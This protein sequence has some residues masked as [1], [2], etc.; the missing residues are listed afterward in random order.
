MVYAIFIH[1]F[2]PIFKSTLPVLSLFMCKEYS[3]L[4]ALHSLT[5]LNIL[6]LYIA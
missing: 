4:C 2:C 3:K 5:M 1:I 6:L